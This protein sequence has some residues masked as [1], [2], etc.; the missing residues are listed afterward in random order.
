MDNFIVG[1]FLPGTNIQISFQVWAGIMT[2]ITGSLAIVWIEYKQNHSD[3]PLPVL[4]TPIN[5]T[6]LHHRM[7]QTSVT[8]TARKA[9]ALLVDIA[10]AYSSFVE[11]AHSNWNNTCIGG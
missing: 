3:G 9:L 10:A 6:D 1:G 2:V 8:K 11:K 4:L 7:Q 5:A